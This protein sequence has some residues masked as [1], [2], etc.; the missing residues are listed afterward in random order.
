ML[1]T[2]EQSRERRI[3]GDIIYPVYN[4]L[5]GDLVKVFSIPTEA[6]KFADSKANFRYC[7]ISN[8]IHCPRDIYLM[9]TPNVQLDFFLD[10]ILEDELTRKHDNL[11][12]LIANKTM[13]DK[14]KLGVPLSEY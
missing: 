8:S 9:L 1:L 5:T 12:I 6:F 11:R 14:L 3:R 2:I 13:S 4:I 10:R 7:N